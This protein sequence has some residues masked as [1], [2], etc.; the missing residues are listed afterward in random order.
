MD[1]VRREL[2][3]SVL[4]LLMVHFAYQGETRTVLWLFLVAMVLAHLVYFAFEV[5]LPISAVDF[6]GS[7]ETA[8]GSMP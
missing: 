2:R 5:V 8:A 1:R 4:A 6:A 7:P 3:G